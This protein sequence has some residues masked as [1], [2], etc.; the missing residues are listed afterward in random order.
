MAHSNQ[1]YTCFEITLE[2][3]VAHIQLSRPEARNSMIPEFWSELPAAVNDL[4]DSGEVR[5]LVISSTGRHFTAGMDLSVFTQP[6]SLFSGG[7]DAATSAGSESAEPPE[8]GRVRAET[9]NLALTL[10]ESFSCLEKARMPVLAAV[11]GGCVGGG[12]DMVCAADM[13]YCTADAFF[14]IQEINIGLT[15]DLGTLQRLPRI[16]P[17]GLARELAYTG[18]RLTADE[19]RA[20]GLVNAVYPDQDAMLEGVLG[21]AREIAARSPLAIWGSKEMLNYTRDHSVDDGLNYVATWQ[22]GMFHPDDMAEVF[23]AKAEGRDPAFQN[24]LPVRRNL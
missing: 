16:I 5:T 3:G 14:C 7:S 19:A 13:R 17:D 12:V 20:A 10:Q 11:Q 15:A 1:D 18:R 6:D 9:R 21:I 24:L 22:S 8:F 2:D 23:A 4:S